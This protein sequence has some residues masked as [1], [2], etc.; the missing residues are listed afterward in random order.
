MGR[1]APLRD[2]I[3]AS[4]YPGID[5]MGQVRTGGTS[6]ACAPKERD[7]GAPTCRRSRYR[8]RASSLFRPSPTLRPLR[9]G[10]GGEWSEGFCVRGQHDG[11][12]LGLGAVLEP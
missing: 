10:D 3:I 9:N 5:A 4:I 7:G 1:A 6:V 8:P 12:V 2:R 11:C